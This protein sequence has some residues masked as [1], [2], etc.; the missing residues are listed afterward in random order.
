MKRISRRQFITRGIGVA[1][2]RGIGAGSL[3]LAAPH[4]ARAAGPTVLKLA[5]P[6]TALHPAQQ[7]GTHFS[8]LVEE[9]TGGAIK[10]NVFAGGQLGSETNIVSG[11][12]TGIVDLT[13]HTAGFLESFFPHIQVLDLPFLFKDIAVAER[14]LDGPIGQQLLEEMP[15]KGIYGFTWGHYGWRVTETRGQPVKEPAD[16]KGLKIR[17]QPGAVFAASFKAVGAIPVVLDIS[18]LYIALSQNTVQG[19][20]LPFMAMVSSKMYEVT[21]YVGLTNH[22][23]NAGALMASKVK[24]DSL[25]PKYQTVIRD[26]AKEIQPYWRKLVAEKSVEN[27]KVCEEKGLTV[28]ETNYEAFHRAMQPVYDEFRDKIGADL[29]EKVLKATA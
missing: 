27:R 28:N 11:L 26:T 23:Y 4:V 8:Q 7:I 9:R 14:L 15:S 13:M 25:E 21:K 6:D 10:I 22:V 29:V 1:A 2:A 19:L 5:H 17:I 16:L 3:S 20:E 18:E 24:F 12:T